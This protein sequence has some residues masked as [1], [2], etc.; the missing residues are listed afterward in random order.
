[1]HGRELRVNSERANSVFQDWTP[2]CNVTLNVRAQSEMRSLMSVNAS[3]NLHGI[4]HLVKW[5]WHIT[6]LL[7]P[8]PALVNTSFQHPS[9]S[10]HGV[11]TGKKAAK[12]GLENTILLWATVIVNCA[13][14]PAE[15]SNP[16]LKGDVVAK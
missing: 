8:K 7:L 6:K 14:F 4:R 3:L 16:F 15:S 13:K 1:M 5:I 9:S 12:H 11:F 10:Y 2:V